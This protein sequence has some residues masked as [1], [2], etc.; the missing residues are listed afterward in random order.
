MHH[1][2]LMYSEDFFYLSDDITLIEIERGRG[3]GGEH[4][5]SRKRYTCFSALLF[6][7]ERGKKSSRSFSEHEMTLVASVFT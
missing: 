7:Q 3:G 4:A 1:S 5:S 2:L 6:K